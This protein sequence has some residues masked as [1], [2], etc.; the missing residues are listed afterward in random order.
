MISCADCTALGAALDAA[1]DAA[2]ERGAPVR[3]VGN[4]P[5]VVDETC[6]SIAIA[7]AL[8]VCPTDVRRA[9]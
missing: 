3:Y 9:A 5:R 7:L 1:I 4:D 8:H 6:E 2:Y